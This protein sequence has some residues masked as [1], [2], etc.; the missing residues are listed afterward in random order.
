VLWSTTCLAD[1]FEDLLK[2]VPEQANALLLVDVQAVHKTALA[3]RL[4]WAKKV[5]QDYLAGVSR[6]PPDANRVVVAATFNAST[7][8]HGWK[9]GL[10]ELQH[11][12]DVKKVAQAEAGTLDKV[13][14]QAVVL[15]PRNAYY[16]RV[17]PK[18]KG[19]MH[20]ANRQELARWIRFTNR[21]S[22][23]VLS[24]Y[25]K[26]ATARVSAATPIVM[27]FDLTDVLD[28]EG[29]RHRLKDPKAMAPLGKQVNL[30][31]M[32]EL[33]SGLK[34]MTVAIQI[35][36]AINGEVRLDF[37]QRV[38][39]LSGVAK[40]LVLDALAGM[41]A[42]IDDLEQWAAEADG[43]ALVLKG[44]LSER[45]AR[46]LVSPLL[47][48]AVTSESQSSYTQQAPGTPDA[49]PRVDLKLDP[50][51]VAS[52]RYF[53]SVVTLLKDVRRERATTFQ[54][55]A[56]WVNQYAQKI[57][58]LPMLNVDDE[59]LKFGAGVSS[60]LRS[61]ANLSQTTAMRNKGLSAQ[62]QNVLADT[63]GAVNYAYAYG[64]RGSA[65]Y[66]YYVP[67]L[68]YVNNYGMIHNMMAA[69]TANEVT[70]RTQT[71]AN[72]DKATTEVRR[73]MVE[74]YNVEF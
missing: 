52:Q 45:G 41:G 49:D 55:V 8:D 53:R 50:K 2:R 5:Q 57:D 40:P 31:Q 27:A 4:N 54:Q 1:G 24:P 51:A 23:P 44:K 19:M 22:N 71:W 58:E 30:D 33:L 67:N 21:N 39:S 7:L 11:D 16:L 66:Q 59:L 3:A 14:E 56:Y 35:D 43:K 62:K 32:A 34:G 74:K 68:N 47:S 70:I 60:T 29:V 73:K 25:L 38:D 63:G 17:A 64:Y 46:Q 28:P 15:S 48:P 20:P 26:Q 37:A 10:A 72:I 12:I 65:G 42:A 6:L 61:M 36:N 69:G 9:I 13:A 18:I